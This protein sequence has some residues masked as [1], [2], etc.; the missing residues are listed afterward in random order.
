MKRKNIILK[1]EQVKRLLENRI[2]EISA[3][4]VGKSL[5]SIECTGEDIKYLVYIKLREFGFTDIRIKYLGKNDE[6]D[7]MYIIYTEGPV[8]VISTRSEYRDNGPCLNI[9]DVKSYVS[10]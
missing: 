10:N 1:E 5:A 7:L 8:F 2:N 9:Y 6:H 3:T 4:E